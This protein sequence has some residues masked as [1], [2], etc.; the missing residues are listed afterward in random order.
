MHFK[1]V[2]AYRS[3]TDDETPDL[4][5]RFADRNDLDVQRVQGT[6]SK[7]RVALSAPHISHTL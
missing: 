1:P 2:V 6:A 3:V 4:I 5:R 7:R